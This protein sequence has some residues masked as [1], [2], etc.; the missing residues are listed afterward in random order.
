MLR[1]SRETPIAS[2]PHHLQPLARAVDRLPAADLQDASDRNDAVSP[3]EA[4]K[5]RYYRDR[6]AVELGGAS[7]AQLHELE[8]AVTRNAARSLPEMAMNAVIKGVLV[9]LAPF[10]IALEVLRR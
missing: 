9:V 3:E 5:A 4:F 1:L 2:L 10:A 8:D 7:P 6:F